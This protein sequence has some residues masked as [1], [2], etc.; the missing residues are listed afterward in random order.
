M[1]QW[2]KSVFC[3]CLRARAQ[4]F[5]FV[6]LLTH[7][8]SNSLFN[9]NQYK[10]ISSDRMASPRQET[11]CTTNSSVDRPLSH[12]KS[13]IDFCGQINCTV[14]LFCPSSNKFQLW[15][16]P[17]MWIF[18]QTEFGQGCI[19]IAFVGVD[20]CVLLE[21]TA[22]FCLAFWHLCLH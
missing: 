10:R 6:S 9:I 7:A 12:N 4:V 15:L 2:P 20:W 11:P 5:D 22:L 14:S 13:V 18:N 8:W 1:A 3:C 21:Y 16:I 19:K 17:G